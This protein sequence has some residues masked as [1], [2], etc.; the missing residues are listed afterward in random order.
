MWKWM[1]VM[2]DDGEAERKREERE[3]NVRVYNMR[4]LD[5][6]WMDENLDFYVFGIFRICGYTHQMTFFWFP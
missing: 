4:G 3:E 5:E 6:L 1:N 2:N